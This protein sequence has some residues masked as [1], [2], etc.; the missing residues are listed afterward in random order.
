MTPQDPRRRK[1]A[2]WLQ[3]GLLQLA[4]LL[5][6]AFGMSGESGAHG[7]GLD[8][9]GCHHDRKNGGY[10]C[11]RASAL[12]PAVA[13]SNFSQGQARPVER[14]WFSSCSEVRALGL[15][16]IYRGEPGYARHLDRD[17]DG[18]ACEQASGR[19]WSDINQG[20]VASGVMEARQF[21]SSLTEGDL[22]PRAN[23]ASQSLSAEEGYHSLAR[24][25]VRLQNEDPF[26]QV[27]HPILMEQM[28][29][30][31][32]STPV[33][34]WVRE[35]E[36]AYWAIPATKES[37]IRRPSVRHDLAPSIHAVGESALSSNDRSTSS[38]MLAVSKIAGACGV[39]DSMIR[40]QKT[41]GM[42]G[43]EA[44]VVRFWEAEAARLGLSVPELSETCDKAVSAHSSVWD[45]SEE[46]AR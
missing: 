27:R 1:W 23:E 21:G 8:R 4:F 41:T 35:V 13:P 31:T 17:G 28:R 20:E 10:H 24:L 39:L 5:A 9:N 38:N 26:F 6:L 33:A 42:E 19:A 34:Y 11:H 7:G 44:F 29:T 14:R 45:V 3:L 43:G 2:D 37:P 16:P 30:I 15:G 18:I 25:S 46:V 40:F 36:N 12:P 22:I 32:E